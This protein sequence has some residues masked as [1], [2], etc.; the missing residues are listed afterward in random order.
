M[1]GI[2]ASDGRRRVAIESVQPEVDGGRFPIKRVPGEKV[3]VEADI[4]GDGHDVLGCLLLY[5]KREETRWHEISMTAVGNDRWRGSFE[6]VELGRYLYTIE[7]WTDRFQTWRRDMR[8]RVEAGQDV[9]AE[10]A[11]GAALIAQASARAGG[12]ERERLR[13][14]A[15]RINDKAAEPDA[16]QLALDEE[17]ADLAAKY[18]DRLLA[19]RYDKELEVCVEREKARFS[20]WY[21]IFPRSCAREP[22]GHGT[23]ADCES[24]L[25]YIESMGF[26][27][28]YFPPIHPIGTTNRKGRNNTNGTAAEDVGSPWA[29]GNAY[30]GHKSI[31]PE[32][33]TV[34]DF[35]RLVAAARRHGLEIA[36]DL[37]LQCSPDHPYVREHPDWFRYRPDGTIQYAENPPK[38]YEDIYPL[39]FE[40]RDWRAL[41]EEL[42]GV[43]RFWLD[44]G[45]R[46]FRV[47]NPH[48]KPFAFWEWLIRDTR[49]AYPDVIFLAEAFT[50]PKV[51]YRL[52]KLGFSQSYT[53]FAWRN[54][55]QELTDYFTELTRS[56]VK[57]YFRSNLW[58][59]TPDILPEY[60]QL[61]SRPAFMVRFALAATL[62][63]SY[64]IYGPAFEMC[65]SAPRV[66]GGEE[67]LNSEKYEIKHWDVHSPWSLKDFIARINRIRKENPALQRDGGLSFHETDNP[68]LLCYSKVAEDPFNVVLMVAN[69]DFRYTQAGWV[70]LDLCSMGLD[71]EQPYQAHDLLSGARFLW[72]GPRNYVEC[73]PQETPVHI[74]RIR[75]K[76][77]TERD[78]DYYM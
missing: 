13:E 66:A 41:W 49:S 12:A 30:G 37:A 34:E 77:R 15:E 26:D 74:L 53:Y 50:R 61:G 10:I 31:A 67:Y 38:K 21:E 75:R 17:L 72:Q 24:W 58:P 29:I 55:K 5:R 27:V 2:E 23:L 68:M 69:L 54:T 64:G 40:T 11:I 57:E 28:L 45:I 18:P 8:K 73:N 59:N 47:D 3:I 70:H 25:P 46:I 16:A 14:W 51:M 1:E 65:E 43:V 19:A 7:G 78:F 9:R 60:L 52:A 39:E 33:G 32:L 20:A 42:R 48:T 62:G 35:E 36:M 63:A 6:V 22:G 56:G 4:F 44:K 71:G 76:V